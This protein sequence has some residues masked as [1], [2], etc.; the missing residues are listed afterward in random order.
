MSEGFG[1]PSVRGPPPHPPVALARP[2]ASAPSRSCGGLVSAWEAAG[3]RL[4][5]EHGQRDAD[6]RRGATDCLRSRA[7]HRA[8]WGISSIADPRV[9]MTSTSAPVSPS[10]VF[11]RS[12]AQAGKSVNCVK[13][14]KFL[15]CKPDTTWSMTKHKTKNEMDKDDTNNVGK[16]R[17][18]RA[19]KLTLTPG[20]H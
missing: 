10:S 9:R 8:T 14:V 19:A 11:F 20:S 4:W 6:A 17:K 7:R 18:H 3:G 13:L 2:S 1:S 15:R 12:T 5:R 16:S